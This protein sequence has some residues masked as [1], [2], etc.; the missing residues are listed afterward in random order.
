MTETELND[1]R[2]EIDKE[3]DA[4]S[5]V[6]VIKDLNLYRAECKTIAFFVS[7]IKDNNALSSLALD[8]IHE[9]C[10]DDRQI[11]FDK[12]NNI[13]QVDKEWRTCIPW[14]LPDSLDSVTI[15][16]LFELRKRNK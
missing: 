14:H 15:D 4:R 13:S 8:A 10:V 7:D 11:T 6:D 9:E 2:A 3:K 12:I 1:L 16:E 5:D